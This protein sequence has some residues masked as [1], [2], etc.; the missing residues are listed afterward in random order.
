M[1]IYLGSV[2]YTLMKTMHYLLMYVLFIFDIIYLF[3]TL[4]I[5]HYIYIQ[6]SL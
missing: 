2:I 3:L 4:H 6:H 1:Y 5:Y